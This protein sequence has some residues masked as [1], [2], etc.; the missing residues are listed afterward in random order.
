MSQNAAVMAE[1]VEKFLDILSEDGKFPQ[2]AIRLVTVRTKRQIQPVTMVASPQELEFFVNPDPLNTSSQGWVQLTEE[3]R[4]KSG[5]PTPTESAYGII[6]HSFGIDSAALFG[7]APTEVNSAIAVFNTADAR[8]ELGG[9]TVVGPHS[10]GNALNGEPA[11]AMSRN[12]DV[13]TSVFI[14]GCE[15]NNRVY[16]D[17]PTPVY[18]PGGTTFT[19]KVR[20]DGSQ[21]LGRTPNVTTNFNLYWD[22]QM[23]VANFS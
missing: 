7:A 10:L 13:A 14:G 6:G 17:E 9:S 5:T 20:F 15:G 3:P 2:R 8:I 22:V 18:V 16:V 1:N 11:F 4:F 23:L 19:C 12:L 21:F